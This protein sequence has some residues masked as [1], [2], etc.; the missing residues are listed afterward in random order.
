MDSLL[1]FAEELER[2]DAVAA[3]DLAELERLGRE[4]EGVR[5]RA[6]TAAA[7]LESLPEA[8][9][10]L[11]D[12]A[13]AAEA[14]HH[15]ALAAV[16]DAEEELRSADE[17]G[18]DDER[19][20]AARA[21]QHARDVLADAELRVARAHAEEARLAREEEEQRTAEAALGD[22]A[23]ALRERLAGLRRVAREAALAPA[24]GLDGVLAWAARARGG[25]LVAAAGIASE[26]ERVGREA[27]EL[28]GSV[29]GDPLALSGAAGVRERLA[30]ELRGR[31]D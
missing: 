18:R 21:A 26:R 6:E 8:R 14:V 24:P 10:A 17:R 22:E 1:R 29:T 2:R 15:A 25:L 3:A 9:S 5:A 20:A 19:L 31:E 28:L 12:E 7:F 27:S 13:L 4:L 30:R 23:R 16:E 11:A